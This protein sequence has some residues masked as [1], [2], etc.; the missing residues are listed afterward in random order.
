MAAARWAQQELLDHQSRAALRVYAMWLNMYPGDSR[1][2]WPSTLFTDPRVVQYWDESRTMG[3]R[4]LSQLPAMVER[5]AAATLPP[6][7]D[8]MWDAYFVYDAGDR[9][10]DPV[11]MPV[12][13]GYPIMVTR[14]QLL[15]ELDA[16][17]TK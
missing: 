16:L 7:A 15:R 3:T 4:Y 5:R 6:T 13:W 12:S 9:W 2:N 8:V 14:D 10:Q 1:A 11:P 17:V